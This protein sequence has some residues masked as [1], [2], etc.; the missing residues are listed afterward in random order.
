MVSGPGPTA[1]Q[2]RLI[3]AAGAHAADHGRLRP[4]RFITIQ[5]EARDRLGEVYARCRL[6]RDPAATAAELDL[7][8]RR[9]TLAS[10]VIVV[11]AHVRTGHPIPVW[12]QVH[13]TAAAAQ[14]IVTAAFALGYGAM[15]VTGPNARDVNFK[16][17]LGLAAED[18]IVGIVHVGT[19]TTPMPTLRPADLNDVIRAWTDTL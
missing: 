7:E 15:W 16:Q 9:P 14:N 13:S 19:Q 10:L 11:A 17:A 3:L 18:E 12:E 1:D 6:L 5:G 8:R 2:V 4:W